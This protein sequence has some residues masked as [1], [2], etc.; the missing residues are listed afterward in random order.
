MWAQVLLLC[1]LGALYPVALAAVTAY[2]G[3]EQPTR[4]A[5]MF[6]AGGAAISIGSEG[7][8]NPPGPIVV[9]DNTFTNEQDRSTVFVRDFASTPADLSGNTLSGP[10]TALAGLG[11]VH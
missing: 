6:L 10:V 4:R 9:K 3:G 7:D 11:K 5:L 1:A 8:T 2:L